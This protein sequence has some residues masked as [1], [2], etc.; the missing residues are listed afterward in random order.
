MLYY[1]YFS[2]FVPK[3]TL[4]SICTLYDCTIQQL[5]GCVSYVDYVLTVQLVKFITY[6][7]A[8]LQLA[9]HGKH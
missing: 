6:G 8:A 9:F 3:A 4:N 2:G 7:I 1:S 5:H